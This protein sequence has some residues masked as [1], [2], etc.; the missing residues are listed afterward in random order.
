MRKS[1][2]LALA[3]ERRRLQQLL[4]QRQADLDRWRRTLRP[5]YLR[6]FAARASTLRWS[7]ALLTRLLDELHTDDVFADLAGDLKP[8]PV[9]RYPQAIA[10]AIALRH[11]WRPDDLTRLAR[12][13][14][15][16]LSTTRGTR[17]GHHG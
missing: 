7:R 1:S 5:H 11:S 15:I 9:R 12:R 6:M 13:L 8:L 4:H 16:F 3:A 10:T 2:R 17:T 14:R